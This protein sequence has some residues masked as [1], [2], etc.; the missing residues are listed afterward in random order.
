MYVSS[1]YIVIYIYNS[2]IYIVIYSKNR[3]RK[4]NLLVTATKLH[5]HL[6][7]SSY[8][9]KYYFCFT[10]NISLFVN[11]WGIHFHI[12]KTKFKSY[13]KLILL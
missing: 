13:H 3:P 8:P 9:E 1:I 2:S 5:H 12:L 6:S 4:V 7:F 11:I 10:V